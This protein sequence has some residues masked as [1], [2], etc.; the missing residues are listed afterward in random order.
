MSI[1]ERALRKAQQAKPTAAAPESVAEVPM[2]EPAVAVP[3]GQSPVEARPRPA[4]EAGGLTA[5]DMKRIVEFDVERL[6]ASGHMPP[7][8]AQRQSDEEM[9]RIKWPLL[10]SLAGRG[11]SAPAR[12]NVILVTSAEPSEGKSYTALNLAISMVRDREI[13]VILVDGDVAQPGITPTLGLEG[14]EGLNDVLE[15]PAMDI[16]Q[17]IY[18]TT[19][20]GLF[21]VPAGKWNER[22]PE[23]IA[24][25]RMPQIIEDLGNRVGNGIVILDS[26]PLLATNEAQVATQYVGHVLMVVRADQTEQRAVLDALAL[27]DK[28]VQVSAVLNGVEASLLSRYYGQY[29]YGYGAKNDAYS[30]YQRVPKP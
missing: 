13:R 5:R 17:V 23:L 1:I 29:Y 25:S 7:E 28:S 27:V 8:H 11:G 9:R 4:P 10:N 3:A 22:S 24:G 18:R 19:V 21:F 15:D 20:D 26:P 16:N 14:A 12:N 6:R 30:R 2:A